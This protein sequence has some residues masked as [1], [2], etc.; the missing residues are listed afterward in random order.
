M[1][2]SRTQQAMLFRVG[3]EVT[4]RCGE[5]GRLTLSH[6]VDVQTVGARRQTVN[7]DIYQHSLGVLRE[8]GQAHHFAAGIFQHGFCLGVP[9]SGQALRTGGASHA[10]RTRQTLE[11][12][13]PC[14][15]LRSNETLGP[16]WARGPLGAR[17]PLYTS[18]E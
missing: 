12:C 15:S 11:A 16:L 10:L 8:H 4:A 2:P 3:V 1:R 5:G 18:R 13:W 17:R 9:G 14:G 6:A 7:R